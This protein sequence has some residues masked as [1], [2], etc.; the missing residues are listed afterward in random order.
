[1][2][3][4][5]SW[6]APAF[7]SLLMLSACASHGVDP[8]AEGTVERSELVDML[9]APLATAE[10]RREFMDPGFAEA[11]LIDCTRPEL[12]AMLVSLDAGKATECE[13]SCPSEAAALERAYSPV[14]EACARSYRAALAELEVPSAGP[15]SAGPNEADLC[16]LLRTSV[17]LVSTAYT[18]MTLWWL[19]L[20][21][22]DG[23]QVEDKHL[24]GGPITVPG[25][26]S[27][28]RAFIAT[29]GDGQECYVVYRGTW[30][31]KDGWRDLTSA[32]HVEC[33]SQ[34]DCSLGRGGAGIYR[35]YEELREKGLNEAIV[36]L[37][38]DPEFCN[39]SV[40]LTGHSLGG[41][42]AS[43]L[44]ADLHT[45]R[46][47]LFAEEDGEDLIRAVTYGEPRVWSPEAADALHKSTSKIR[48]VNRGDLAPA[49]PPA[50][51]GFR[52]FGDT[53]QL[54]RRFWLLGEYFSRHEQQD[55][56]GVGA[57]SMVGAPLHFFWTY[58]S[59][60]K[61]VCPDD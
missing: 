44:L 56:S 30:G 41:S 19:R 21:L 18:G 45:S 43:M 37:V 14:T 3:A 8:S 39:D 34:L 58:E 26:A 13:E 10:A 4:M 24:F 46:P 32:T 2:A 42:L 31:V 50:A 33:T 57:S 47:D 35:A 51:L 49:W 5:T 16:P 60:V 15:M 61:G 38:E 20:G 22:P 54:W 17:R 1:M 48:V 28:G 25:I 6:R 59:N 53:I 11:A 7:C 27:S 29:S 12:Q 40:T 9:R 23:F 36:S 55:F 52:H